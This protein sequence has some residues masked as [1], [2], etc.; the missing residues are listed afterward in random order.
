VSIPSHAESPEAVPQATIVEV[1]YPQ[2]RG[3][4]GLRGSHA[5]LS[6]DRTSAPDVSRGHRHLFRVSVP[7]GEVL[8]LKLVRNDE[9]WAGGRNYAVHSG[10]HLRLEPFFDADGHTL[11]SPRTL[12]T[13]DG[14]LRYQVLLPPSYEEQIHRRYPTLY[15][16]DGQALWTTSRD[17]YGIWRL[18][19]MMDQL[20]E[21]G[22]VDE[23]IIVGVETAERR[24]ERLSPVADARHGGGQG[25]GFLCALTERLLPEIDARYRTRQGR[26]HTALMGSSMG[27]LFAFWAA[28][29]RPDVFGKAACLS[30]SF[31]WADRWAV[32]MVQQGPTPQPLPQLYLDS[33]APLNPLERDANVRD[34]FNHTRSMLRALA[35]HAYVPGSDLHRLVFAGHT[36]DAASWSAR[37]GIPLQL[38]FPSGPAVP[39]NWDAAVAAAAG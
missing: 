1:I 39:A 34:G 21:L 33:G 14:A 38:L 3:R 30:S 24:L 27:G 8:E 4:I 13:P 28:W 26:Q 32:R 22:A 25:E 20:V 18:D 35:R 23:L 12:D 36:H 37:V 29:S 16:M 31:W 5:P 7:P 9:D 15:V 19:A 17:P 11:E 6:W 2:E 10:D